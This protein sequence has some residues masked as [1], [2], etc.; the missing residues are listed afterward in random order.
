MNPTHFANLVPEQAWHL[1]HKAVLRYKDSVERRWMEVSWL[2]FDA[3]VRR[4][5]VALAGMGVKVGDRVGLFSPNKAEC[6]VVDFALYS[7]RAVGVPLYATSTTAQIKYILKD[8]GVNLLFVGSQYQYDRAIEAMGL[9]CGL[10]QLV[11][12]DTGVRLAMSDEQSLYFKD[13]LQQGYDSRLEA[14]VADRR[15]QA[16]F[17]DLANILYTSGTSGE[18][19]GVLITHAMYQEALRTN[20]IRLKMLSDDEVSLCFLPMTHIFEKAWDLY[21]LA[22]GFR[23]DINENPLEIQEV[24]KE[25][26]P[27][28]M[29]S[30]PRF[31]EKVHAGILQTVN[32]MPPLVKV[33]FNRALQV[34]KRYHLDYKRNGL[35]PPFWTIIGYTL[36][37][38][39]LFKVIKRK[40]GLDRGVFFPVGGAAFS[41]GLCRF[42]R[43]MG[44][45]TIQGYGLTESTATVSVF[46]EVHYDMATVGTV[47]DGLQ[48]RIGE[49]REIQLKGKTITPGYFN[50]PEET[51]AAFTADGF[52][53]TGDAGAF[54]DRGELVVTERI[55]DLFKTANGK[56]V[57]PQQLEMALTADSAIDMAA[58]IGDDRAF[59]TALIV[60][61]HQEIRNLA[62][63]IGLKGDKVA[64]WLSDE[65][66]QGFFE[67]R[68]RQAQKHM[69]S[70]EQVRRFT[71]LPAPFSMDNGE[72]T[73]TLKLRR[74]VIAEHYADLIE[75]MYR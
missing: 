33:Y 69:A 45:P 71:L 22:R 11:V 49:D 62:S 57:A 65:R 58:I 50:K 15:A 37:K 10:T 46:S 35:R 36:Y 59:V 40:V 34:G 61:N 4:A 54:T 27:T 21:C 56:Y 19:K 26:R 60:P 5:A 3:D 23:I 64:D 8:A 2:A 67:A 68:I 18:P 24:L 51:T 28:V 75:G 14:E 17:A 39:T 74:K 70:Y 72:L 73:N 63:S 1:G 53:R 30:V 25:V 52:F 16:S 31:W 12:F 42:F 44:I 48:V 43:S 29:C 66:L 41:E 13:F 47:I 9:G 55:K 32:G 20:H 7:L 6:L 38:H